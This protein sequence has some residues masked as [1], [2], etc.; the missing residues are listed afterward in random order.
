[1]DASDKD[2]APGDNKKC[3][4]MGPNPLS[5]S[6]LAVAVEI[7]RQLDYIPGDDCDAGSSPGVVI[8]GPAVAPTMTG[9]AFE[10]PTSGPLFPN[11]TRGGAALRFD[12]RPASGSAL[13]R[14]SDAVAIYL[15][16]TIRTISLLSV[17]CQALA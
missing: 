6:A 11:F 2:R 5:G 15:P 4:D 1:M 8:E 7:E 13:G 16:S 9:S 10:V 3:C 12:H 14:G 17:E